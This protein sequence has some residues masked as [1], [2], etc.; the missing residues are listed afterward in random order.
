MDIPVFELNQVHRHKGD[1]AVPITM[2]L[3]TLS[4]TQ[5]VTSKA[6]D[7]GPR[8]RADKREPGTEN[9]YQRQLTPSRTAS[10]ARYVRGGGGIMPTAV[11]LNVREGAYFTP[12]NGG[13]QGILHVPDDQVIWITDGQHRIGGL[14]D[15]QKRPGDVILDDYDVPVVFT[16]LSYD[17]EIRVFYV[18]NKEAR[19]VPTDLTAELLMEID[20]KRVGEGEKVSLPRLRKDVGTYIGKRLAQEAGPWCGKIRLAEEGKESVKVRP[21]GVSQ[22][23]ASLYPV[24]TDAWVTR[25]VQESAELDSAAWREIYEVVRSYWQ[26]IVTLMPDAAGDRVQYALQK[27]LGAYVFNALFPEFLDLARQAGDFSPGFFRAEL[28]RLGSWAED[29]QWF[30]VKDHPALREPVV[31]ASNR[32]SIEY[33]VTQCRA[34]LRANPSTQ[35]KSV[36]LPE[37]TAP[38]RPGAGE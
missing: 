9:G 24:L 7:G 29:Q 26:A 1:E 32:Q 35:V 18:V 37:G 34:E 21:I 25:R 22:F 28:E 23:G 33:I 16:T 31:L 2:Y 10:V 17:E 11:L 14:A 12:D 8:F 6:P 27:P 38:P 30:A 20:A 19:N 15:V 4:A 5:L 36:V 3:S 13:K